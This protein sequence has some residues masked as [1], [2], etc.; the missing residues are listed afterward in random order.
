MNELS[1]KEAQL[2]ELVRDCSSAVVAFSG[3]VD[4]SVVAAIAREE[5]GE[6]AIAVTAVSPIYPEWDESAAA[7]VVKEVGIEHRK[8]QTDEMQ[9]EEF[10]SN[11]EDRCYHCKRNR[12]REFDELR[13]ELGFDTILEGTNRDDHGEYRPGMQA[14]EEFEDTVVSPLSEVG[15]TKEETRALARKLDVPTAAKPASPCLATRI[16]F[17]S[18]ITGTKLSRIEKA[19]KFLRSLGFGIVR[20]RDHGNLARIEIEQERIPEAIERRT[21]IANR[22][23]EIGYSFVSLDLKGYRSGSLHAKNDDER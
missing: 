15:I 2:R 19:E 14:M 23:Q 20:V 22:L 18:L 10:V 13:V 21:E 12:L 6:E 17:A 7:D 16:P 3:G 4:S 1:R 5:L 8:L 11:P 9:D